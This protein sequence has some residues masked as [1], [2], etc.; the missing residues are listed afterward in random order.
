MPMDRARLLS[1]GSFDMLS[2]LTIKALRHYDDVNLL[3]P[4]DVDPQT[5]YR[6]YRLEQVRSARL[7]LALRAVDLP[8]D[9]LRDVLEGR[10][11]RV[12]SRHPRGAS[13]AS[14]GAVVRASGAGG[15]LDEFIEKGVTVP[16]VKGNRIVMINIAVTDAEEAKNFYEEGLGVEFFSQDHEGQ[17][18]EH[19]EGTFGTWPTDNFFLMQIYKDPMEIYKDPQ[20]AGT[21]NFGFSC[22]DLEGT[23]KKCLA[24]G[25][26]DVHGPKDMPGMPRVAAIKDPSGND[27][28]LYQG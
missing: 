12:R 6:Y 10:R 21:A 13:R 27:I 16:E 24:A 4:A 1:I 28:G 17:L 2:G 3:K 26:I 22:E 5:G 11:P 9:E 14:S 20:R 23:Y 8:L 18:A 7:I 15:V 25:A 19:Y